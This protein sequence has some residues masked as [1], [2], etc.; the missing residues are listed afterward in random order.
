MQKS[1][2][3]LLEQFKQEFKE[4]QLKILHTNTTLKKPRIAAMFVNG[5]I[6]MK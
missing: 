2:T 1:T 3:N 4:I 5:L 6:G